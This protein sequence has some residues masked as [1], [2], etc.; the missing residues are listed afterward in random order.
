MKISRQVNEVYYFPSILIIHA[1]GE[2]FASFWRLQMLWR[3]STK[4]VLEFC[5]LDLLGILAL[6]DTATLSCL[7]H[8]F[9]TTFHT[10]PLPFYQDIFVTKKFHQF[11]LRKKFWTVP[12]AFT[13]PQ[14]PLLIMLETQATTHCCLEPFR[15][16]SLRGWDFRPQLI[17]VSG[18]FAGNP[19]VDGILGHNLLLSQAF[20]VA[21]PLGF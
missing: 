6:V 12:H 8:D 1:F 5:G 7:N 13:W 2:I 17:V 9:S 20:S 18:L 15:W 21:I 3:K 16:E 11:V 19:F 10:S 14:S 4:F